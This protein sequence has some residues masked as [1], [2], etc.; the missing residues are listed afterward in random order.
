MTPL[1]RVTDALIAH[2]CRGRGRDWQCASHDDRA[3]SLSI[4][5]GDDGRVLMKCHAGCSTE[6]VVCAL[7]L[8]MAD[9]FPE[10]ARPASSRSVTDVYRYTDE[11]G[12]L[13]FEVVRYTSPKG[14][15]QRRPDG[16]GG[17]VWNLNETRRVLYRLPELLE[18]LPVGRE[19]I[20]IVE[21]EKDVHAIE[22]A[23]GVATCNP[24]GAGKWRNEYAEFL[25]G[26]RVVVVADRDE[27]GWRHACE[28]VESV[29][30]VAASVRLVEAGR[31]KDAYDHLA[32]GLGLADF[33]PA[34]EAA[35][36]PSESVATVP[37]RPSEP[38]DLA[39]DKDI[40]GRFRADI[41]RAG[42][43]GEDATAATEFLAIVSRVL[44]KPVSCVV[45]GAPSSGKSHTTEHVCRFFPQKAIATF[46][47]LSEKA[48]VLS[49]RSFKHRTIVVYEA[50]ALR[51]RAEKQSGDQTA[52]FIRSLLSEGKASYEMSVKDKEGGWTTRTFTKEGPTNL[53][54]TTTAVNL[55]NEN[56]T[57]M[58]S[59][60][61]N[62]SQEQTRNVLLGLAEEAAAGLDYGS[63]HELQEWLWL[64]DN[65]VTIPFARH[66]A[67]NIPPV[68]VRL[69][70]DFGALLSL[71]K[72]H[73]VLHQAT[74]ERDVRGRIIA[75]PEDYAAVRSLV[76]DVVAEG[77]EATVSDTTR[78]T[79]AAVEALA[80]Q[81]PDGVVPAAAVA[82]KLGL[83]RSA[84]RRRL[85]AA[86]DRGY[87]VNDEERR[88]RPGRYRVGDEPPPD[89]LVILPVLPDHLQEHEN[90]GE[91]P[92][93]TVATDSEREEREAD[94]E[95]VKALPDPAEGCVRC[96][97][98]GAAH[99][100][101]HAA[102]WPGNGTAPQVLTGGPK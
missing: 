94:V 58:L 44:E 89:E 29:S 47:G 77:V 28:V 86:A 23:G 2:G 96:D 49:K 66:L 78:E 63:W 93:G 67:E 85:I 41:H 57:R 37:P 98:Y 71:I 5:A 16:R 73:A 33:I 9:L 70:R 11:A 60:T 38:P 62:D 64:Q 81:H 34:E 83:D 6:D 15:R 79:V 1:E 40:L 35:H 25:M 10:K 17:Y 69:R 14:F 30:A 19:P 32:A 84:A 74:R 27:V 50:V 21:G 3:A 48:L 42:V 20:Y 8:T 59:L 7:G 54:V 65:R 51:E 36:T 53:I 55:H 22:R 52:Y 91:A 61:T 102:Q 100:G 75:T 99:I 97:R 45:K 31:G 26:A 12:A 76:V 18:A 43:I 95:Q 87:V 46:T 13:L 72:A 56:E 68:A 90:A 82:K 92:G 4:G 80:G 39:Y 88:G 101:D 24:G